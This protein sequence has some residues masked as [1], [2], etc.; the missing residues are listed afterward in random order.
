M[1]GSSVSLISESNLIEP[2][3]LDI[4]D[5]FS[6][7]LCFYRLADLTDR[8]GSTSFYLTTEAES[9]FEILCTLCTSQAVENVKHTA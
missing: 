8:T 9:A 7:Y 5:R 2:L 6:I 1:K 4:L 3:L